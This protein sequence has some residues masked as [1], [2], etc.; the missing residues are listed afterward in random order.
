[1]RMNEY[2]RLSVVREDDVLTI[3]LDDPTRRNPQSPRMW[4]SLMDIGDSLDE[5]VTAVILAGAGES[6]S[7]GLDRRLFT[8]EGIPGEPAL[9]DL[10]R[11][12][13]S[14][15]EQ[16]IARWQRAFT[17]WRD[18]R[19]VVIAVV[20]GHAVGAG[21]QLA[22]AADLLIVAEDAQMSMRETR[23]G[24]I[25]DLGGT[26][27]LI[28]ALGYR[29]ALDLC[30]SGRALS[31]EEAHRWGLAVDCVPASRLR[32][33]A[34]QLI[35]Q[36]RTSPF[37]AALDAKGLLAADGRERRELQVARERAAQVERLRIL[38]RAMGASDVP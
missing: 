22:L 14:A 36:V 2:P 29:R 7:S 3:T 21:F 15:A 30:L 28:G 19:P 38:D 12:E 13:R 25:P 27:E 31:G 33:R 9:T 4:E 34:E 8:P 5:G 26:A 17:Q 18:L 1:M 20:Q 10:A 16:A 24:L 11:M 37:A 23:I 35:A 6:F 32:E